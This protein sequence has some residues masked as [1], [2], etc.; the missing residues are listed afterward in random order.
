M[1]PFE[2]TLAQAL[3][4]E[5]KERINI[6]SIAIVPQVLLQDWNWDESRYQ[7]P[8]RAVKRNY[9]SPASSL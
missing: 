6:L 9:I 1:L 5:V 3:P 2:D 4:I 8:S 7:M